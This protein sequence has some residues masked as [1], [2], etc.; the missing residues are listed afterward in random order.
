MITRKQYMAHEVTHEQFYGQFV[1][2]DILNAVELHL[3]VE[4]A[5]S[6]DAH[7]ND[8]P[9][10]K[11]DFLPIRQKAIIEAIRDAGDYPS[12]AGFVCIAKEAARQIKAHEKFLGIHMRDNKADLL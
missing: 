12:K 3:G 7:F 8:V 10:W 4:I 9:L 1:T 6:T 5:R 2:P 11:W